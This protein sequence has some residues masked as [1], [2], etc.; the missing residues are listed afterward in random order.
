MIER[1]REKERGG[2]IERWSKRDSTLGILDYNLTAVRNGFGQLESAG[3][4]VEGKLGRKGGLA[5][6]A[7]CDCFA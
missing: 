5:T 6:V 4:A 7:S 1:R 2:V 3:S